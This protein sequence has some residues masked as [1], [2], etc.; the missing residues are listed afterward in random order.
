ME[1]HKGIECEIFNQNP[2]VDQGSL[3]GTHFGVDETCCKSMVML[4]DLPP[5]HVTGDV[6]FFFRV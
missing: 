1:Y 6:F 4:R 2:I 5:L 3:D